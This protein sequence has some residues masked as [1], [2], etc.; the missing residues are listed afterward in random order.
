VGGPGFILLY[1]GISGALTRSDK[2]WCASPAPSL[3]GNLFGCNC[4]ISMKRGWEEADTRPDQS[5]AIYSGYKSEAP[6]K[7]EF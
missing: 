1:N 6:F 7:I 2:G 3:T 4:Q 5:G